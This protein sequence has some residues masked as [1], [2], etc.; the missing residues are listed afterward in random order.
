MTA[1]LSVTVFTA[2]EKRV[3][4]ERPRPFGPPLSWNPTTATL[5]FGEHD[6]V[7]ID[8]LTTLEEAEALGSWVALHHRTLTT[9]YITH[10][11][12]DH[13]AGLEGRPG[14]AVSCGRC[15]PRLERWQG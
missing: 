3:V 12:F 7:L 9:I 11:H 10:G 8:R 1:P 13:F 15:R 5:I 14:L 4:G 6:A 2:P